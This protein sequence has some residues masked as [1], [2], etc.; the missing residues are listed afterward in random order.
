[1]DNPGSCH[2]RLSEKLDGSPFST[3]KTERNSITV[4]LRKFGK[5]VDLRKKMNWVLDFRLI[6]FYSCFHTLSLLFSGLDYVASPNYSILL[7]YHL[8]VDCSYLGT[9]WCVYIIV[10]SKNNQIVCFCP[11]GHSCPYM[12]I[13]KTTL[14][15]LVHSLT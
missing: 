10:F 6:I 15:S 4:K 14:Y 7:F 3:N 5:E 2:P 12:C 1:M 8:R 9:Y 13:N 11:H